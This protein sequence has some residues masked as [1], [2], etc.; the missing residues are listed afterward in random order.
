MNKKILV[1]LARNDRTEEMIPYIER[2]ARPGMNVVFL[3]RYPVDGFIWAKEEYGMRAALQARELVNYYSWENNLENAKRRLS[4]VSE[5]LRV[6]GVEATVD[7][8][9]GSL[10]N[11]VRS[12]TINGDV[13][14]IMTGTGIGDWIA[15]LFDGTGSVFDGF[16]RTSFSPVML[17]NPRTLV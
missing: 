5:A 10:K 7:L 2:V 15:R 16:K 4:H 13:H 11:A 14:L 9:A 1:P 8:Y 17:I 6:I 3:V 12:H